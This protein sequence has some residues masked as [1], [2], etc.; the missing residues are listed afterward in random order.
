MAWKLLDVRDQL[1]LLTRCCCTADALAKRN[2]LACHFALERTQDEL[3]G[4]ARIQDIEAGPVDLI[5]RRWQG[6]KGVPDQGCRI[7]G[8]AWIVL[9]KST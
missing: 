6:M 7:R 8:V 4:G 1:C 3:I 9:S 5:A 2:G